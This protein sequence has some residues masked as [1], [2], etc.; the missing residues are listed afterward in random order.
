M[1]NGTEIDFVLLTFNDIM[2][3]IKHLDRFKQ[4]LLYFSR[5]VAAGELRI[6]WKLYC[7]TRKQTLE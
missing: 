3:V 1:G 4:V 2:I 5:N 6:C 7:I